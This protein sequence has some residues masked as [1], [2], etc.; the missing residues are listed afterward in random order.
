MLWF[1]QSEIEPVSTQT[2]V[3]HPDHA[4]PIDC[5]LAALDALDK[6]QHKIGSEAETVESYALCEE[7]LSAWISL[8]TF[9]AK[10]IKSASHHAAIAPTGFAPH[11]VVVPS[12]LAEVIDGLPNLEESER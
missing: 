8:R 10:H 4:G 12:D 6:A 3:V 7:V 2:Y 11:F 1:R 9:T 5:F